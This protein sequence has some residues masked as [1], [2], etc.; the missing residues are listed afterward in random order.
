MKE[1]GIQGMYKQDNRSGEATQDEHLEDKLDPSFIKRVLIERTEQQREKQQAPSSP[2]LET[3]QPGLQE[4][5]PQVD[6]VAIRVL[7]GQ[8]AVLLVARRGGQSSGQFVLARLDPGTYDVVF[9][10]NGH[11][12][13]VITGVPVAST[14]STT[15]VSTQTQPIILPSSSSPDPT[16]SGTIT[17]NPANADVVAFA[18][19]KQTLNPG[20]TV[21]VRSHSVD[22]DLNNFGA[23]S[24]ALPTAAPLLGAYAT[25][26]PIVLSAS[27]QG[28]VAAHY[29]IE[30]S[31]DGYQTQ[32][33]SVDLSNLMNPY[34]FTLAP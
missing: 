32:S 30:A 29:T 11:A 24:L 28:S 33:S 26:L 25:P 13:A 1:R 16:V 6:G 5:I 4:F 3:H 17:L 8:G 10:A 20:P 23:Y 18:T 12:T 27:A 19:A 31:A 22:Q 9:V 34:N 14:T 7:G 21:T 2:C 15:P